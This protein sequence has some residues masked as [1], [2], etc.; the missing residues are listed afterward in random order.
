MFL[1]TFFFFF[2]SLTFSFG[3]SFFFSAHFLLPSG[4]G[5][6]KIPGGGPFIYSFIL[7]WSARPSSNLLPAVVGARLCTLWQFPGRLRNAGGAV[8]QIRFTGTRGTLAPTI[9]KE[10]HIGHASLLGWLCSLLWRLRKHSRGRAETTRQLPNLRK[11]SSRSGTTSQWHI[12]VTFEC[13]GFIL[14]YWKQTPST[15]WILPASVGSGHFF[16]FLAA[17]FR[18]TVLLRPRIFVGSLLLRFAASRC[19][20]PDTCKQADRSRNWPQVFRMAS[21]H[22]CNVTTILTTFPKSF[23]GR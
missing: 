8:E 11:V 7:C 15:A 10:G 17:A 13:R 9:G 23:T 16:L 12:I 1:L 5:A 21:N 3:F 14:R 22:V 2:F 6:T 18:D 19:P 4:E 20:T